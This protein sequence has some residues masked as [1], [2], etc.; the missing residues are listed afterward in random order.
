MTGFGVFK[1]KIIAVLWSQRYLLSLIFNE[2][3]I[4]VQ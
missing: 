2:G 4:P 3:A 1:G